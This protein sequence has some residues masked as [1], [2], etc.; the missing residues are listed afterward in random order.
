MRPR[1]PGAVLAASFLLGGV[2][3]L[4]HTQTRPHDRTRRVGRQGFVLGEAEGCGGF[5][6]AVLVIPQTAPLGEGYGASQRA[7]EGSTGRF[8][9]LI[10]C[11]ALA[12][13][14]QEGGQTNAYHQ[15]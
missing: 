8:F 5:R 14:L 6:F 13:D 12:S 10:C 3:F 15:E 1:E 2:C 7:P 11:A 9:M 4:W